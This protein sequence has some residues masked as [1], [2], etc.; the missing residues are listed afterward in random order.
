MRKQEFRRGM[1]V[2]KRSVTLA[3][4]LFGL[5]NSFFTTVPIFAKDQVESE[6]DVQNIEKLKEVKSVI[7]HKVYGNSLKNPILNVD[8]AT[9]TDWRIRPRAK[10]WKVITD[11]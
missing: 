6:T 10:D 8:G 11:E 3:E 4:M 9:L 7:D 2:A 5:N 1:S